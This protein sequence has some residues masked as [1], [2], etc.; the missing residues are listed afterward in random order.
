MNKAGFIIGNGE[1]ILAGMNGDIMAGLF[2]KPPANLILPVEWF[3]WGRAI[4]AMVAEENGCWI[5][6]FARDKDGYAQI[7]VDGK[8]EKLHRLAFRVRHG[9]EATPCA[10]HSC[11]NPPCFNPDH[12]WEGTHKDNVLDR[13][14]KG[15]VRPE[16]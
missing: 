15:R 2:I 14:S 10:C 9:K 13:E 8:Q 5:S 3:A 11:D 7:K 12:I 4:T 6:S 1:N 16:D